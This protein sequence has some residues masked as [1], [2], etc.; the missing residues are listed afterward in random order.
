LL[1]FARIAAQARDM[2]RLFEICAEQTA[3]AAGVR[4]TKVLRYHKVGAELVM[5]AG[6]GWD[7]GDFGES[8]VLSIDMASP[9]GRAFQTKAPVRLGDVSTDPDFRYHP[10]L[11]KHNILSVLNVPVA[12]DGVV[13]GVLE[14]DSTEPNAFDDD[15]T[16]FLQTMAL[17]LALAI[18]QREAE[19]DRNA[20]REDVS[21]R[22]V[23]A[24]ILLQEQNHRVRNYFQMILSLISLRSLKTSDK[25]QRAEYKKIMDRIVAIG[26]AHD[27]L[28]VES[29]ENTVD[30]AAYLGALCENLERSLDEGPKIARDF[31][32]RA[33]RSDR[34]VPLGLILNELLTN[35][36]KYAGLKRPD[37]L[38]AV[39]FTVNPDTQEGSLTVQDNG[40]GMG[41]KREG[42]KGL[43]FVNMMAQQLS[44]RLDIDSSTA[45]T[46]VTIVFPLFD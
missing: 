36:I 21:A 44:G 45:G 10:L 17:V 26:L 5:L 22:L 16:A 25:S 6:K 1:E 27:L 42:S 32:D 18:R 19:R 28:T 39:R 31:Q 11:K 3:R 30:V 43:S 4:H 29:G 14:V 13:W 2:Q 34:I 24:D 37:R 15:D 35:C 40:P 7:L 8:A 38:I 46:K 9:P 33:L 23:Q 12:M 41:K 20:A